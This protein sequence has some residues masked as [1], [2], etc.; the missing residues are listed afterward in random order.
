MKKIIRLTESDLVKIVKNVI[1][2]QRISDLPKKDSVQSET[3]PS[4]FMSK[5]FQSVSCIPYIFQKPVLDMVGKGYNKLF[6]K[7]C[8]GII[9][10]ES[11]YGK[12]D[13]YKAISELK[14][15]LASVGIN[16]SVGLGQIKPAKA[17][18]LGMTIEELN[19][20]VGA[21]NGVYTI[22]KKNYDLA[23][24]QGY[25]NG[26]SINLPDGTGNSALDISILAFNMGEKYI[27]QF[28][29]TSNPN[30]KGFCTDEK[31]KGGDTI[32]KNKPVKNYIPNY[33]SER[34]DGVSITSH[35]Y[36]KEVAQRIKSF[37]CPAVN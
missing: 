8:L 16:A 21:I 6:I 23:V 7:T 10:R 24:S 31:T 12:S 4:I 2:E 22:L 27:T 32:Y 19:T 33:K 15:F 25:S 5:E 26:P 34:W 1:L 28:C 14:S 17:E 13:R 36:I 3:P 30:I 35:G 18:E 9:G 20:T 29:E 11:D 37:D